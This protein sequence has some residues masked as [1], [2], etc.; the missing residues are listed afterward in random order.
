MKAPKAQPELA[1]SPSLATDPPPQM[2]EDESS[3][4]EEVFDDLKRKNGA[5]AAAV[6]AVRAL[7]EGDGIQA[8]EVATTK[9]TE[10]TED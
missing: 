9:D 7:L 6:D 10:H 1:R 2:F 4:H 8:F 3:W 5:L